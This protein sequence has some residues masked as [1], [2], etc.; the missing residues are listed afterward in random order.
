MEKSSSHI[1][2]SYALLVETT[3]D[4]ASAHAWRRR[5]NVCILLESMRAVY[6]PEVLT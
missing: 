2:G 4:A 3:L 6:Q 5:A 1:R